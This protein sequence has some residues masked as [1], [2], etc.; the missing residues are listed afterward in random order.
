MENNRP[1][2]KCFPFTVGS[3][4]RFSRAARTACLF[5][6]SFASLN[7]KHNC[8]L[9]RKFP[10]LII[11]NGPQRIENLFSLDDRVC[12]NLKENETYPFISY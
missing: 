11:F 4:S 9:K 10:T 7:S 2:L 5:V 1:E 8:S 3:E 6:S 12:C